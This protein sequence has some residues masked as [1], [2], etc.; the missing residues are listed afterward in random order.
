MKIRFIL[1]VLIIAILSFA[2]YGSLELSIN[3]FRLKDICPKILGI[4]ACY[5]VAFMFIAGLI[6]QLISSKKISNYIFFVTIGI[7][8]VM[9]LKGT[10]TEL[11]GTLVCPR[12]SGGTPMC[13]ISLG[14]CSL[15]LIL[16]VSSAKANSKID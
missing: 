6:A 13:F 15:L 8:F 11:S 16:K 10:L 3:N 4:P 2:I 1:H 14:I 9:A 5:I 7:L 12:T